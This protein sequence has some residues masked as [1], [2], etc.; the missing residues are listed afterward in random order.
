M[1]VDL[2]RNLFDSYNDDFLEY[3]DILD[4]HHNYEYFQHIRQY[5]K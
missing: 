3:F 4:I 5:L 1:L 2:F